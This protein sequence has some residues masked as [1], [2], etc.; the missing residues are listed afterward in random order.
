MGPKY[1]SDFGILESSNKGP[2]CISDFEYVGELHWAKNMFQILISW[3]A[4]IRAQDVF[5]IFLSWRAPL[6][7]LGI[8]P[9]IEFWRETWD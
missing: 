7:G 1:I 4:P 5:Q 2:R 9:E 6:P 8:V 3:R